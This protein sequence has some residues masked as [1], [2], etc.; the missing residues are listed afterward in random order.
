MTKRYVMFGTVLTVALSI[1]IAH[2]TTQTAIRYGAAG[3]VAGMAAMGTGLSIGYAAGM[4]WDLGW[5]NHVG[6]LAGFTP[7]LVMGRDYTIH[8]S[9][10]MLV[11]ATLRVV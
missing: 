9:M 8:C 3:M 4:V 11:P 7:G 10:N 5:A 1:E 2:R 6:V